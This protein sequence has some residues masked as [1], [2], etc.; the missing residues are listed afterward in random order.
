MS[1][2]DDDFRKHEG[3]G[4]SEIYKDNIYYSYRDTFQIKLD[5]LFSIIIA[6]IFFLGM[7]FFFFG[8]PVKGQ[9]ISTEHNHPPEHAQLHENFYSGWM[10]PDNRTISCCN[11]Q[12]CAPAQVKYKDGKY[13]VKS[14]WNGAWVYFPSEK[15][16]WQRESPDGRSHACISQHN[17]PYCLVLGQGT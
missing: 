5:L 17:V 7:F 16:D 14:I 12:D 9:E 1:R 10:K 3:D 11:K 6:I 2:L 8:K 4:Q 15:I 13:Y